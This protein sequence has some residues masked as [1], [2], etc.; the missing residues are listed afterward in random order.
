MSCKILIIYMGICLCDPIFPNHF[1]AT[2]VKR[3]HTNVLF[4]EAAFVNTA[5][6]FLKKSAKE[7]LFPIECLV[8]QVPESSLRRW[9]GRGIWHRVGEMALSR[10]ILAPEGQLQRRK[11]TCLLT[12]A[13]GI[14]VAFKTNPHLE[15]STLRCFTAILR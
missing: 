6:Q 9:Q 8:H 5:G 3:S 10:R 7:E 1:Q 12:W 13:H 2:R 4:L 14:A 15:G 11:S